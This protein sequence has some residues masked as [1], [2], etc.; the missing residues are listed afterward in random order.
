VLERL[1]DL[2]QG[3]SFLAKYPLEDDERRIVAQAQHALAETTQSRA[4]PDAHH[5]PCRDG[6]GERPHTQGEE[7]GR[8]QRHAIEPPAR[9]DSCTR[10]ANPGVRIWASETFGT[11]LAPKACGKKKIS[12]KVVP[13][14]FPAQPET[15]RGTAV[16]RF[17]GLAF[18]LFIR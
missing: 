9:A 7:G 3:R 6:N 4:I 10:R 16:R 2:A 12:R 18:L 8:V 1:G 5:E 15:A 13:R 11:I 17:V 14:P